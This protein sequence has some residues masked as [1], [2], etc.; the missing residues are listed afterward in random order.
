MADETTNDPSNTTPQ[1]APATQSGPEITPEVQAL[2]DA[3]SRRAAEEAAARARDSAWAEARRK[4]ETKQ[5][6]QPK[7]EA[8]PEPTTRPVS[9]MAASEIK[10]LL[11]FNR[12][13]GRH[14]FSDAQVA[15]LETLLEVQRPENVADWVAQKAQ[16][17]GIGSKP[18][19]AT[20]QTAQPSAQPAP[21]P[22]ATQPPAPAPSAA[23][24]GSTVPNNAVLD[25]LFMS[26][27]VGAAYKKSLGFS[28]HNLFSKA[29]REATRKMAEE[30]RRLMEDVRLTGHGFERKRGG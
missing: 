15:D 21:A 19:T 1:T 5:P 26:E 27:D 14:G 24:A 12:E 3:A 10:R 25:K 8:K 29:S 30:G 11:A 17:Y 2:I 6:E 4:Y 9:G 28:P 16:A 22:V 7:P 13:V 20:T 18:A 23:P